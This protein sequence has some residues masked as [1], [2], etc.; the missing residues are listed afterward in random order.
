MSIEIYIAAGIILSL[1][2]TELTGLSPGGIIVP[3]YVAMCINQPFEIFLTVTAALCVMLAVKLASRLFFLFGRRRYALCLLLG[4]LFKLIIEHFLV[5]P[6]LGG[7]TD[8]RLIGWLIP[9]II[10]SDMY[11]QG[12]PRTLLAAS[13]VSAMVYL[14]ALG[15]AAR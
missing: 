7:R 6:L 2:F 15:W 8:I 1:L 10:A 4:I 5:L 12:I 14:A 3:G 9:G 11:K 13:T